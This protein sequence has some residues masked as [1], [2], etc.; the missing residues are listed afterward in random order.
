MMKIPHI[1][2]KDL[3]KNSFLPSLL[4]LLN[5][6]PGKISKSGFNAHASTILVYLASSRLLPNRMF[7]LSVKFWIQACCGTYATDP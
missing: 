3:C 1:I 4:F 7:S 5:L 6:P 2:S